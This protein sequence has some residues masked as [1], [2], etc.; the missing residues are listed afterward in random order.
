MEFS[1]AFEACDCAYDDW[2]QRQSSYAP[3]RPGQG[4]MASWAVLSLMARRNG[5]TPRSSGTGATAQS[6]HMRS[7]QRRTGVLTTSRVPA[8]AIAASPHTRSAWSGRGTD[9]SRSGRT[10]SDAGSAVQLCQRPARYAS[11]AG[12]VPLG[13][14]AAAALG[15]LER[16]RGACSYAGRATSSST[17]MP[18]ATSGWRGGRAFLKPWRW[19][20]RSTRMGSSRPQVGCQ[21]E[22]HLRTATPQMPL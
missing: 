19:H 15:H 17:P 14:H 7:S 2:R 12:A 18:T 22:L 20:G 3:A 16:A 5:S 8:L 10:F 1:A 13:W 11:S 21:G 6:Q 4:T 9:G